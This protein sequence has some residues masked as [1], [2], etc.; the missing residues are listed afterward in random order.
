MAKQG[1][2]VIDCDMHIHEPHDLWQRYIDPKFK[3]QGPVGSNRHFRDIG[4]SFRGKP[5]AAGA[6]MTF[7]AGWKEI[8]DEIN[9]RRYS[10]EMAQG[11]DAK[12]QLKAMDKEGLDGAIMFPTRGLLVML[13]DGLQA[14]LADAIARAYND[15]LA[16]FC[17]IAP[18]RMYGSAMI[19]PHDVNFAVREVQRAA[20]EL[21]FK[22]IFLPNYHVNGRRWNDPVY[23]P[24]WAECQRQGLAVGFHGG[25]MVDA[26]LKPYGSRFTEFQTL[27]H[28]M[29]MMPVIV[30][31][32]AGG[33]AARYPEL[34]FGFFESNCSWI[35]WFLNRM[36]EYAE[37]FGVV[38]CPDMKLDPADY[39]KRQ[40]YAS[41]ECDEFTA[42][43]IPDF[44]YE[45]N[46]VFSTDYPH[47]DAKFPDAVDAFL[48]LPFTDQSRR[49]YLWDN[50][51]RLYGIS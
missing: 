19:S 17:S 44:G 27:N 15:W 9:I 36:H 2:K 41:V 3:D 5:V 13:I 32:I 28:P 35:P 51:A 40:C 29:T 20:Q 25:G 37:L 46:I 16:E 23:E 18:Q 11:F 6:D 45:D 10:E 48:K 34:K 14:P 42:K 30:D 39:F 47:T 1:F 24:L 12:S 38:E 26:V 31:V 22:G 8:R 21:K 7:V 43:Y 49:K 50:C 33:V 4:L